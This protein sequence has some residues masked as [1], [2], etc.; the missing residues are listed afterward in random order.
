[1]RLAGV[2]LVLFVACTGGVAR[3]PARVVNP[4]APEGTAFLT[5]ALRPWPRGDSRGLLAV[6]DP[7]TGLVATYDSA[8]VVLALLRSGDRSRAA[9]ILEG[10]ATLQGKDGAIPFSVTL[11]EPASGRGYVRSGAIAWIGYAAAEYL[12][13]ESGGPS[14][15]VAFDLAH[16]AAGY[17]LAHQV[18]TPG[19]PREGLVRGGAGTLRYHVD[20]GRIREA[21]EPGE[22]DWAS[23]EHNIDAYFFLRALARVSAVRA[24]SDA[25]ARIAK[26]LVSRAWSSVDGQFSAGIGADGVDDTLALDCASWGSVLL[27][28]IGDAAQADTAFDVSDGRY[29]AQDPAGVR[30]HRPYAGGPLIADEELLRHFQASMTST[31]WDRFDGVWVEGSAGVALAALRAGRPDRARAILDALEPLRTED[32]AMPTCTKPVPFLFAQGSGVAATAWV[33]LVRFELGR[34]PH[35]PALWAP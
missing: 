31:T 30:G 9:R 34:P 35:A 33:A 23:V 12:D 18:S 22:I 6:T 10:L 26:A 21:L 28:A 19:D 2:V 8:L 17:L 11:E 5:G 15:D 32:G 20:G 16:R 7:S 29:A 14:R 3:E 25:A 24:Y 1:M 13:A 27:G 4:R